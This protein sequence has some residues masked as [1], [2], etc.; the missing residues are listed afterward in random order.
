M[1]KY[2]LPRYQPSGFFR[3][4][5]LVFFLGATAAGCGIAWLYQLL[6]RWIPFIYINILVVLGFGGALAIGGWLAVRGGHCR[7]R[8]LALILALPLAAAP[9]AA[10]YYWDYAH[11]ISEISEKN[12]EIP[13]EEIKQEVTFQRY[14]EL[15]REAGWKLKG[16]TF[17]GW[18]VT[19][20]WVVEGLMVFGCVLFGVL[21]AVGE[22]YCEK[23]NRWCEGKSFIVR[24]VGKEA[25]EPL[26]QKGDLGALALIE[27][28]AEPDGSLSLHFTVTTC[29][30]CSDAGFLSVDEKKTV[31]KKNKPEESSTTLVTHAV[32]R[33]DH[34]KVALERLNG[35]VG[36]KL[37]AG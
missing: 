24:G 1:A 6:V 17:N 36:Q 30:G 21:A 22:P 5:T 8:V 4:T 19:A 23:C 32:L 15:K 11:V 9:L 31:M 2:A 12:P 33:S 25:A 29:E 26:L 13:T 3:P 18:G 7:N 34:R 35:L 10:S 16:S 28:P 37:A 14:L 20:V 27:P